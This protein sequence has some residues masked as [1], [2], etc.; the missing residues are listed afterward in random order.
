M[1]AHP[2]HPR[3]RLLCL[4]YSSSNRFHS[5]RAIS[6]VTKNN[7]AMPAERTVIWPHQGKLARAETGHNWD[8]GVLILGSRGGCD[9]RVAFALTGGRPGVQLIRN[10]GR[11]PP[12]LTRVRAR[13]SVA[14]PSPVAR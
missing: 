14:D 9:N 8:Q 3:V 4:C 12:G 10:R 13:G 5:H 11:G 6:G 7:A 1:I 2:R